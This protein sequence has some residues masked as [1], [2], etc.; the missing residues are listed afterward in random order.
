MCRL[1]RSLTQVEKNEY[2]SLEK[3][4]IEGEGAEEED[5]IGKLTM[6]EWRGL[7]KAEPSGKQVSYDNRDY[8]IYMCTKSDCDFRLC[9]VCGEKRDTAKCKGG[10]STRGPRKRFRRGQAP[11][12]TKNP[13]GHEDKCFKIEINKAYSPQ[14]RKS[15]NMS[16]EG[17]PLTCY[18]CGDGL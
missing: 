6:D 14:Y 2:P 16:V 18:A 10:G 8:S 9:H 5:R 7:R 12:I 3:E 17:Y 1:C 11:E 13:C 15:R 4:D